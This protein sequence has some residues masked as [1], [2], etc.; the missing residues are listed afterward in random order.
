MIWRDLYISALRQF[1]ELFSI[2]IATNAV[3]GDI[4]ESNPRSVEADK[5]IDWLIVLVLELGNVFGQVDT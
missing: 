1:F 4:Q 2:I 3:K 5:V